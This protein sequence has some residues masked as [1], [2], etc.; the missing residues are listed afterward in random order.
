MKRREIVVPIV[1]IEKGGERRGEERR[2]KNHSVN[3]Q[4]EKDTKKTM[5]RETRGCM[6]NYRFG[7]RYRGLAT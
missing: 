1:V 3:K 5:A 7:N 4:V 6:I 2:G